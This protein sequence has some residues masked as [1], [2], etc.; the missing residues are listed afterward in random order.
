MPYYEYVCPVHGEITKFFPTFSGAEAH[1]NKTNCNV[2]SDGTECGEDSV[3]IMSVPLPAHFYGNPDGYHKP[4]PTKR[5]SNKLVSQKTG[6]ASS[7]G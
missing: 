7:I 6:N 2:E 1:I 4:S 3:R 5:H